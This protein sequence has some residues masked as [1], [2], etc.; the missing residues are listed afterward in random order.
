MELLLF[1]ILGMV[2]SLSVLGIA[3]LSIKV[4][5][6]IYA[7]G[8]IIVGALMVIFGL[9][10]SGSSFLEDIPQSGAMGLAV[11]CMPGMLLIAFVWRK[12]APKN[13]KI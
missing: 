4:L 11:F 12:F 13:I 5:M 6:P 10:W 3:Y 1:F 9:G 7:W 8:G 2:F